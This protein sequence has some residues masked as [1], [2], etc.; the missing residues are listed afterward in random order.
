MSVHQ[1]LDKVRETTNKYHFHIV[2]GGVTMRHGREV[3]WGP[4]QRELLGK[5]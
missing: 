3:P 2:C 4:H 1:E 5:T